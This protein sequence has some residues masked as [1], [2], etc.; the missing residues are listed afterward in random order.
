MQGQGPCTC[1]ALPSYYWHYART[2]V[3]VAP[4]N[5]WHELVVLLSGRCNI[6]CFIVW[7]HPVIAN[8]I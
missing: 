3:D 5:G 7:V 8:V 1:L 6:G 2:V 4:V